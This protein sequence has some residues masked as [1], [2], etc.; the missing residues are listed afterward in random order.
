VAV[1]ASLSPA[2]TAVAMEVPGVMKAWVYGTYGDAGMIKLDKA[3][4][5]PAMAEDQV[6][7]KVVAV[8]LKFQF[9]D[10]RSFQLS[11]SPHARTP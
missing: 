6:V 5:V 10:N 9:P 1:S 8:A 3:A 2:T 7:V 4:A 11:L